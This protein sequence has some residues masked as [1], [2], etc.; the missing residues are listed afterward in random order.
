MLADLLE[1]RAED[2]EPLDAL[3]YA[4]PAERVAVV[5]LHG[6]GGNFHSGPSRWLP[7]RLAG[8]GITH[9]ALNMRCHDLAWSR[10][11]PLPG[12]LMAGGGYWEDV[13]AAELDA[14]AAVAEL[15]RRGSRAVVLCGHSSG[16]WYAARHAALRG[17]VDGV[18]LLSPL[19]SNRS[20]FARWF[21]GAA[22]H[23]AA[24]ETAR[25]LVAAGQGHALLPLPEWYHAISAATLLEK[26][27]EPAGLFEDALA[28]IS[29]P[30]LLLW[31]DDEPRHRLWSELPDAP[32]GTERVVLA[33][34]GHSY[35]GQED[36]VAR[37]VAR[38]ALG[39]PQ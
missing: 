17:G 16:G 21:A 32:G 39:V 28:R 36:A 19:L 1:L 8:R 9:L 12:G 38:L 29:V 11:D 35:R 10:A 20:V 7:E 34:A 33:G 14:G 22:E 4:D 3:L 15:R 27:A 23:D 37:A 26:A 31:S 24:L 30:V 13:R 6:K 2:G 18:V 5:H 25:S